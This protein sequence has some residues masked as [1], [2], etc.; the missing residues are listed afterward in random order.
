VQLGGKQ[1]LPE[2][3]QCLCKSGKEWNVDRCD[4]TANSLLCQQNG[5]KYYSQ[6]K[7]RC[8]C[9]SNMFYDKK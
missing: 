9:N 4:F 5:M 3:A 7:N 1:W 8:I 2:Q 6:N